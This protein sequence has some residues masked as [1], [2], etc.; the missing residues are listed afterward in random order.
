MLDR[1]GVNLEIAGRSLCHGYRTPETI[2][3]DIAKRRAVAA[4]TEAAIARARETA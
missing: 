3:A 4:E 2:P 1:L